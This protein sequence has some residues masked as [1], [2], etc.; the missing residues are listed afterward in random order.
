MASFLFQF[1]WTHSALILIT[2]FFID[3]RQYNARRVAFFRF[4]KLL[5]RFT[6][7]DLMNAKIEWRFMR[8]LRL[9]CSSWEERAR[10]FEPEN[11]WRDVFHIFFASTSFSFKEKDYPCSTRLY[12]VIQRCMHNAFVLFWRVV[13]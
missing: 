9:F 11:I 4:I 7:E 3:A 8:R 2:G 12:A 13:E 5:L 1:R 10:I 6:S